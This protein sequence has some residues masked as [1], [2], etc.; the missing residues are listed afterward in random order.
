MSTFS[1]MI[2]AFT[3]YSFLGW[4][5]ETVYCSIPAKKFVYRGFLV[6][7]VCPIYGFGAMAVISI[8]SP[9]EKYP[10]LVFFAAVILT[11]LVE[12]I[13]GY[14]LERIFNKTWWDYSHRKYNLHGRICLAFSLIW[15]VLSFILVYLIAPP[16]SKV[17]SCMPLLVRIILS[18]IFAIVFVVD[19]AISVRD[20]IRFNIDMNQLTL[21]A[22]MIDKKKLELQ[23]A[24]SNFR[25]EP[26]AAIEEELQKL[27]LQ[28]EELADKFMRRMRRI[29]SAFPR[30]RLSRKDKISLR[31]RLQSYLHKKA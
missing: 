26:R 5:L 22:E 12:Y 10:I 3:F 27:L 11:S 2:I 8:L 20:A 4:V 7:P 17:I 19:L 1:F 29:L 18:G 25:A 28:Q 13:T 31:D 14:L 30:M 9:L 24:V 16:I 21:F 15:G 6:G 23:N